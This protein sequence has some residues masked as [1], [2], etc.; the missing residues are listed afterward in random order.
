MMICMFLWNIG[1][2][3]TQNL[4]KTEFKTKELFI[5]KNKITDNIII[6]KEKNTLTLTQHTGT[7]YTKQSHVKNFT[8]SILG[9]Q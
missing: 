1:H 7:Y 3:H 8:L 6:S 5:K 4:F 2:Y 9:N